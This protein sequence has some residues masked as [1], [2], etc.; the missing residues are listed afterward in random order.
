MRKVPAQGRQIAE[1]SLF[2]AGS[3]R[4]MGFGWGI[5][6]QLKCHHIGPRGRGR[7]LCIGNNLHRRPDGHPGDWCQGLCQGAETAP[8]AGR[9]FL[10]PFPGEP[11]E[12]TQGRVSG[13]CRGLYL[14]CTLAV[15]LSLSLLL[16]YTQNEP[17]RPLLCSNIQWH[18]LAQ[19]NIGWI[20]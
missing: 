2:W 20:F 11:F 3:P 13:W 1:R 8:G 16:T 4:P 9:S 19:F 6:P 14:P 12:A 17:L 15:P 5:K 10:F 7:C 18:L